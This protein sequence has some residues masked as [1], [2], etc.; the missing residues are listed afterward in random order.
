[1]RKFTKIITATAFVG[2]AAAGGSA[3][4]GSGITNNA[5]ASQF[6]GGS[7]SQGITGATL[8]SIAYTFG[9]APVNTAVHSFL[10]TFGDANV[11]AKTPT[12]ALTGGNAVAF[13]CTAV[14]ATLHTSTCTTD[15]AD[16]T[17]VTSTLITV[18]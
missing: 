3:L 17:G 6:V 4:T 15:G 11:D 18:A 1:M 10:V 12:V 5:G 14:E 16:R 9:D 13:T 7:I 2:L 8:S